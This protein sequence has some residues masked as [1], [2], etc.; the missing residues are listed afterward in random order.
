MPIRFTTL[1]AA[2]L[3]V[4]DFRSRCAAAAKLAMRGQNY[5]A[6]DRA[7]CAAKIAAETFG[8]GRA[9]LRG[10]PRD[11]LRYLDWTERY[12]ATVAA[13][14]AEDV[15]AIPASAA[16][17]SRLYGVAMNYRRALDRQRVRDAA[18]AAE[19]ARN[20]SFT[21]HVPSEDPALRGTPWGARRTAVEMLRDL[22]ALGAV[23]EP[24]PLWTAAYSAARSAAGL[25]SREIA[26]ELDI[27]YDTLRAHLSRAAGKL[28]SCSALGI[29]EHAEA[30]SIPEPV[31]RK[32]S[33]TRNHA[34]TPSDTDWRTRPATAAPVTC[35]IDRSAVG[36]VDTPNWTLDLP[37]AT[38]ARLA[39]GARINRM[40]AEAK[41][42]ATRDRDRLSAGLPATVR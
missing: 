18:D 11:V 26:A 9:G 33:A 29:P 5:D 15:A 24:G 28:P 19:R 30:L 34:A 38:R 22:G 41:P 31:A 39:H 37:A 32:A 20:D 4:A 2:M 23:V 17:F 14:A 25:E 42:R 6:E 13:L 10:T 21:P 27:G 35:R 36:N 7:D 12:P 8:N 16:T 40:R 1:P 3:T